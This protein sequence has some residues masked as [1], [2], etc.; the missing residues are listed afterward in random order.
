MLHEAKTAHPPVTDFDPKSVAD[1]ALSLVQGS[2]ILAKARQDVGV[3]S[4][5]IQH[6]RRYVDSLFKR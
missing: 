5:N 4:E 3:I 2:F 1:M 6:C